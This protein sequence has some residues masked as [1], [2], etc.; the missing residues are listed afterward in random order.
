M[1][2][3]QILYPLALSGRSI[4]VSLFLSM[5]HSVMSYSRKKPKKTIPNA[6]LTVQA[7]IDRRSLSRMV[8]CFPLT[9]GLLCLM[10]ALFFLSRTSSNIFS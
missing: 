4:Y 8:L 1:Q 6:L 9:W 7:T 10:L 2:F 3:Y 5:Q